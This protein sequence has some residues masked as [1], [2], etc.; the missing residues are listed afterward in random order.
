MI[1]ISN[2]ISQTKIPEIW[3]KKYKSKNRL[4][5]EW[6]DEEEEKNEAQGKKKIM[7]KKKNRSHGRYTIGVRRLF[8]DEL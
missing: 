4:C 8:D 6:D 1:S 5:K 2:N 3:W 7:H